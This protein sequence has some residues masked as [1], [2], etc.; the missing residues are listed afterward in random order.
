MNG[1]FFIC[2]ALAAFSAFPGAAWSEEKPEGTEGGPQVERYRYEAI[3]MNQKTSA[4]EFIEMEFIHG[5][6]GIEYHS[7]VISTGSSE[8]ISIQMDKEARF[9]SARRSTLRGPGIPVQEERIWRDPYRVVMERSDE[10][11]KKARE[12]SLP[13]EKEL[14]VDGSLLALLRLFPFNEGRAWDLFM[15]DFS[16]Y[17]ITVTVHQEAI[18]KIW[19]PAGEFE[20]YRLVTVVNIPVLK[21]RITYWLATQKPHFL[22][23]SEGKRGPFT[24]SYT[25]FL[26]SSE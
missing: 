15:V 22:V 1:V 14:A 16:G 20:C 3:P 17:S 13:S 6:G 18:E 24:P 10:R 5:E 7:K 2:A 21:P 9:V 11:G 8:E 12:Y 19:V 4:K 26:V 23:K 25:T